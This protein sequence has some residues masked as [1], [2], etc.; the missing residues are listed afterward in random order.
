[1][2]GEG[3]GQGTGTGRSGEGEIRKGV[4]GFIQGLGCTARPPSHTD[5]RPTH[6]RCPTCIS[7]ATL[8]E[9]KSTTTRLPA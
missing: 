8:G 2:C 5:T 6:R 3:G 7:L 9:E 1:M 4:S